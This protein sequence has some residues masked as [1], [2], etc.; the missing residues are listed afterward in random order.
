VNRS[1]LPE[2]PA[3][4]GFPEPPAGEAVRIVAA[5]HSSCGEATRV[6]L[7]G[8]V[9][10]RAVRRMCCASCAQPFSADH[11]EEIAIEQ[12]G[13][14][15]SEPAGPKRSLPA[16]PKISLPDFDPNGRF[17]T[18]ASLP[19]AAVAVVVALLLLQGGDGD[20]DT[21]LED[22]APTTAATAESGVPAAGG[23]AEAGVPAE[24]T[25][26]AAADAAASRFVSGSTYSLAL[27]AGWD[28]VD[29]SGGATFSA[30]SPDGEA[31]VSLWVTQNP[32]LSYPE[33]VNE[34]LRQLQ[35]LT[36]SRPEIVERVTGPD[37]DSTI[38]RL[39]ADAPEGEPTYQVTLRVNG[40]YRYY[41]ATTVQPGAPEQVVA[42][43]ELIAGSF[44]PEA[45]G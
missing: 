4:G 9:P 20:S 34:S 36:G 40:S 7:P 27:P 30:A 19:L 14:P 38:V 37:A 16:L 28:E 2:N 18:L 21:V 6:R 15:A 29:P 45:K 44:T 8:S 1:L 42:D 41:L 24:A 25:D 35:S 32:K 3:N 12:A 22:P 10:A 23:G 17:W 43:A 11:V 31:Q 5:R 13:Q 26:G 39:A 33:F